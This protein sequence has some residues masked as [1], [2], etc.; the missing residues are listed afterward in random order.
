MIRR[1]IVSLPNSTELLA[2]YDSFDHD[3][4]LNIVNSMLNDAYYRNRKTDL[5]IIKN[6]VSDVKI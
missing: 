2:A 3:K 6:D 1:T 5:I 4:V